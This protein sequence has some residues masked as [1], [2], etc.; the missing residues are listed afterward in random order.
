[1]IFSS[2]SPNAL[3]QVNQT[4]FQST[5]LGKLVFHRP[6]NY[7]TTNDNIVRVSARQVRIKLKE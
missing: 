2:L 1:M 4:R 5:H 3:F 6:E 7:D